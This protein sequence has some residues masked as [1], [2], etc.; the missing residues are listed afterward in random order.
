GERKPLMA[1]R[2]GI[3][4]LALVG[5]LTLAPE[6]GAGRTANVAGLQVGLHARGLYGGTI[7]G[8]MG[9]ATRRG[10]RVLQRR[11]GIL[12]DGIVGRQTRR[13]LGRYGRHRYRGRMLHSGKR[14]WDVAAL[15]FKLAWHGFPS[16]TLD[17]VFGPHTDFALRRFQRWAG[18]GA[19][20]VAGP[21]TLRA[22]RRGRPHVPYRLLRPV[23]APV[24]D[25]FGPRGNRFHAGLDL[26]APYGARVRASRRGRVVKASWDSRGC[27]RMCSL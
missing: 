10:V 4:L 13:A 3:A 18:L 5:L 17:G 21:A 26:P 19:D 1:F 27:A 25:R 11:A 16:G 9:P 23:S 8:I 22:L 20:G 15:Q 6:A 14:G 24:G 12:V 7:D 2:A